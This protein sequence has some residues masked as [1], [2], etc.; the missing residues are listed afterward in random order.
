M[1]SASTTPKVS[2][3]SVRELRLPSAEGDVKLEEA[4]DEWEDLRDGDVVRDARL[5]KVETNLTFLHNLKDYLCLCSLP[6]SYFDADYIATIACA[7]DSRLHELKCNCSSCNV[8]W[9]NMFNT[10]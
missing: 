6:R 3:S 4:G 5:I 9:H 2:R 10:L 1:S 7:I 8:R